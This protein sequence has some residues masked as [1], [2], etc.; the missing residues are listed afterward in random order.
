[1]E[2][3]VHLAYEISPKEWEEKY[4]K[5]E[6]SCKSPYGYHIAEKYGCKVYFSES[7]K[8]IFIIK[9]LRKALRKF[10]GFDLI[11]AK[12][13]L[14]KIEEVDIIWTHTEYEFLALL[15]WLKKTKKVKKPKIICQVIW[16]ADKW[17]NL[18]FWKKALYLWLLKDADILT[19]LSSKNLAFMEKIIPDIPKKQIFFGISLKSFPLQR[20]KISPIDENH[21]KVLSLGND[22]H[23]D[24]DT[25]I[26]AL[27]NKE[28]VFLR[29]VTHRLNTD[30]LKKYKN[31][32][33]IKGKTLKEIINYYRWADIVVVPLKE[34]LHASGITVTLEAVAL[35][36]PVICSDTGGLKDYF[37]DDA[38]YYVPVEDPNAIYKAVITLAK[39][40]SLRYTL[41]TKAQEILINKKLTSEEFV[42]EHCILSQLLLQKNCNWEV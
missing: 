8:E 28:N 20:P 19:F 33:V 32:E 37:P 18:S 2:I 12:R 14:K 21:I 41:I 25:L 23:R 38:L 36:K 22:I 9:V 7:K 17:N 3:F 13:N 35:G 11:H 26:K 24:W 15:L 29:I 27:G 31:I 39:D 30:K 40:N 10:L 16:L 5:Q 4:K 34:N 42:K 1:M 6:V